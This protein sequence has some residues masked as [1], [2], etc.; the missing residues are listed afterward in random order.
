MSATIRLYKVSLHGVFDLDLRA[1][2]FAERLDAVRTGHKDA[3]PPGLRAEV[4][5]TSML[6]E[7]VERQ[8]AEIERDRIVTQAVFGLAPEEDG[9]MGAKPEA[10]PDG[11]TEGGRGA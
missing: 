7:V 6:L 11:Q 2:D 1:R 8:L 3:P 5:R 9:Q 10:T 4:R